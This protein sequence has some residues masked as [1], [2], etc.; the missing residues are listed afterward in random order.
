VSSRSVRGDDR[1]ARLAAVQAE[2]RRAER[3]RTMIWIVATVSVIVLLV[4]G[5]TWAIIGSRKP[6]VALTGLTTYSNLSRNHVETPVTYPETPPV[7]GNHSAVWQ[8]CGIYTSPVANEHAVHSL[9]HG[10]IWITY[11]PDLA[12]DQVKILQDDVR[13]QKYGLLSP[14]TGLPTPVVATVWGVQLKLQTATDPRLKAFI[15]KY[16][17]GSKAPEPGGE[18]TGG[19]G[20]PQN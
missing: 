5:V 13:G 7:G 4:G 10:A 20:T 8:N 18:C 15:D 6:T 11:R 17:D 9:E 12:A 14:Y 3:R 16:A 1:K 19:L 2:Q